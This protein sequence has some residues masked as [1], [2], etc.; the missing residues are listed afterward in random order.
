MAILGTLL[1]AIIPALMAGW[2][3]CF[4]LDPEAF[5]RGAKR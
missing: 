4:L 5:Q 2:L 1:F 3:I